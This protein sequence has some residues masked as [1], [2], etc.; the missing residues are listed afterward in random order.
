MGKTVALGVTSSVSIYKACEILRGFQKAG[1]EVQVLMTRN[2]AR[3]VTPFLFSSLSGRAAVTD[4]FDA[5][6]SWSVAHVALAKEA[7]L[8]CVA[9]ATANIIAKFAGGVADDSLS[10]FF[11]AARC[12]ILV[13]PAMNETMFLHPQTQENIAKLKARGV[14]FVE[15]EEGYL[16]CGDE[17]WGRLAE[18]EA[19][20][21]EGLR[22]LGR[23]ESLRGRRLVVTAGPT[24]EFLDAVRFI[25]NPSS[26]KMG[27]E[28]A[29]EA[30]GRGAEVVLVTG[31]TTL[32][33]PPGVR[34]EAVVTAAGMREAVLRHFGAADAV[35]MAAAV[36]DFHFGRSFAGK[37]KK[38]DLA[39]PVE[40]VATPDILAELGITR[41]RQVLVGFAAETAETE[42]RA[43]AKLK[44]K[45]VDLIVANSVAEPG[46]GFGAD[47]NE[48]TFLWPDGRRR[49]TSRLPKRE[50]A[51]AV[52]DE[53]EVLLA[54]AR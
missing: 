19:I 15:P 35:L 4:L 13:A 14:V 12:P 10:T 23:T 41:T 20:V 52:L 45:K 24:R 5:P 1:C 17:G 47:E 16:A 38:G 31:P 50:I 29:R 26:G 39:G 37:V 49:A 21:R 33:P 54:Q 34:V 28:L 51:A 6:T 9:P 42:A 44:A 27:F 36:S 43:A 53:V 2:A 25:S 18:P 11:L 32:L 22:L 30:A 7:G 3:L 46:V 40:L 48:V 8:L